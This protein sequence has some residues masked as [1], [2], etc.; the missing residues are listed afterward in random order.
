MKEHFVRKIEE[1]FCEIRDS[2]GTR[3]VAGLNY[4]DLDVI[5]TRA[6][7]RGDCP[8]GSLNWIEFYPGNKGERCPASST[9]SARRA[10]E[11]GIKRT[12]KKILG[13]IILQN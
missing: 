2:E 3:I 13:E 5:Y 4:G 9:D 1:G 6:I 8:V 11:A 7:E 12:G 10:I